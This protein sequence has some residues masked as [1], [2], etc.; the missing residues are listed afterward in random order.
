VCDG[1]DALEEESVVLTDSD[2][3]CDI[4][5]QGQGKQAT[6]LV[7]GRGE[8]TLLHGALGGTLDLL[9]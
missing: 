6:R 8:Q 2:P 4:W 1:R 7:V 3:E 9:E 5:V